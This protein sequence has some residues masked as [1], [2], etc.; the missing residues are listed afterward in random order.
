MEPGFRYA[1]AVDVKPGAA[2]YRGNLTGSKIEK[3]PITITSVE[4]SRVNYTGTSGNPGS[5]RLTTDETGITISF[6]KGQQA[7][8]VNEV[9]AKYGPT[10]G[11]GRRRKHTR[12]RR[13][14]R[15]TR[16]YRK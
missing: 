7:M 2:L 5:G 9:E 6:A 1:M 16:R 4:G 14:Q 10:H 11:L 13:H 3:D 12:R 15:K 8:F